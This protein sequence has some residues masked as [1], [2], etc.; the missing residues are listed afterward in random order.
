MKTPPNPPRVIL[1]AADPDPLAAELL[2]THPDANITTCND[3]AGLPALLASFRPEVVYSIRFAGTPGYPKEALFGNCG[4]A[5]LAV[6]GAGVDHLG[7][8]NPERTTVTN[9]AGVAAGIMAEYAIGGMLHFMLDV[10]GLERDRA[11]RIWR[12]RTVRAIAGKTVL[13]VGLGHTGRA[14]AARA[15]AFGMKVIGTRARP[16]DMDNVDTV[17][18]TEE[19]QGLCPEAD[20]IVVC[21]PLL[22][23]TRSLIDADTF[24]TMKPGAVLIDVSRGGVVDQSALVDAL[25]SG[26]LLGACLDVFEQEPL[27]HDSP[28]WDLNNA[29]ISPHCSSVTDDWELASVRLFIDN[30][31]RWREGST[32]LNIV[33]PTRGY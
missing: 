10:P 19:L 23:S 9:A 21:V 26:R 17:H 11:A 25:R 24:A 7:P 20:F 14:V 32:L 3:Y 15:K 31:S 22:D 30:L 18:R 12:E 33:D 2:I 28:L 5:W 6:G 29:L 13:I 8:W 16:C 1:H 27:P 4:P